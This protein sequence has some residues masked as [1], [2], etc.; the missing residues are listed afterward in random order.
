MWLGMFSSIGPALLW[1]YGGWLVIHQEMRLGVIV[2][3]TTLLTKLYGPLS[4][5]AQIHV[6][7]LSS[8]ALF[9]RIYSVM[10]IEPEVQGGF[11]T[12]SPNSVRGH[13]EFKNVSF[14]Y[15]RD[16]QVQEGKMALHQINLTI[17]PGQTVALVGPSGAGKTTLLNM[18]PRFSDP[19]SGQIFL[20]GIESRNLSLESLRSQM[21]LVPQDPF[22]FHDTVYNNLLLAKEKASQEDMEAACKAAQIH[23]TIVSLSQGYQTIVGE[24]G[25]RLSGGERQRLAIARVLLQSPRIVLLDEATSALD[26]VVERKIQEALAFLLKGRTA[27]VIAHRLST[28]LAADKIIVLDKGKIIASGKHQDL[29]QT[30]PLY[31]ILYETQFSVPQDPSQ[32]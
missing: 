9:R 18:I 10:D 26:T 2:A 5:L 14:S 12:I 15:Q 30:N 3:F 8:I 25:Y 7:V 19:I 27:I 6:N 32:R 20:D 17:E 31:K 11:K 4:Q 24:R 29:V 21:G 28:V 23:D 1:G 16:S 13:L 22:F